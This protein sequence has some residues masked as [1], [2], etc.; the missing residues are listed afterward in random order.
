MME[1]GVLKKLYGI[2]D[3]EN[4]RKAIDEYMAKINDPKSHETVSKSWE[5]Y[6]EYKPV[7]SKLIEEAKSFCEE[8]FDSN[9]P[10]PHYYRLVKR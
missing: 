10:L 9:K 4:A 3:I 7:Q 1:Y 8:I 2:D 6:L 5:P